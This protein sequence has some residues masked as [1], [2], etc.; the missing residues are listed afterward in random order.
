MYRYMIVFD[1]DN[2]MTGMSLVNLLRLM[3][4]IQASASSRPRRCL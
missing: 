1:A 3:E 2:I 4:K